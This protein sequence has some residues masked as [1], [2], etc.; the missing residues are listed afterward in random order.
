MAREI[1]KALEDYYFFDDELLE[2]SIFWLAN[3]VDTKNNSEFIE[4][5]NEREICSHCGG[6]LEPVYGKEI[7]YELEDRP[8]EEVYLYHKCNN[9]GMQYDF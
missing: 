8:S 3:H 2:D 7:H 6:C 9:C 5:L 1:I 4:W